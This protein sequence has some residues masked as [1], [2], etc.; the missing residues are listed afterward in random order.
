MQCCTS[1]RT[2]LQTKINIWAK[3]SWDISKIDLLSELRP[4][5]Q[6]IRLIAPP[7]REKV[8]LQLEDWFKDEVIEPF[9]LIIP[10]TQTQ[11]SWYSWFTTHQAHLKF[12]NFLFSRMP[13]GLKCRS[14]VMPFSSKTCWHVGT[15][16]G[17]NP[18]ILRWYT[19]AH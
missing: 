7:L 1:T 13:F 15:G 17:R 16:C 6:K 11:Y 18:C 19:S 10:L 2:F 14:H 9:T 4:L 12:F 3:M 5:Q 8:K